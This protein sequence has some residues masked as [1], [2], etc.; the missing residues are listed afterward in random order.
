M[1]REQGYSVCNCNWIFLVCCCFLHRNKLMRFSLTASVD[2]GFLIVVFIVFL[3]LFPQACLHLFGTSVPYLCSQ[4]CLCL[5][6]FCLCQVCM[7]HAVLVSYFSLKVSC[8]ACVTFSFASPVISLTLFIRNLFFQ[9]MFH[10]C[11]CL[12][13]VFKYS[14]SPCSLS[15]HSIKGCCVAGREWT[16]MQNFANRHELKT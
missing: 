14:I 6:S 4:W 1:L 5:F 13:C 10:I 15:H 9:A 12:M 16:Q 3:S 2:W 7:S 8:P 11:N